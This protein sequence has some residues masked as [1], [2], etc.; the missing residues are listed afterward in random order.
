MPKYLIKSSFID[1]SL[2]T[3]LSKYLNDSI[4]SEK[5]SSLKVHFIYSK[6]AFL[7]CPAENP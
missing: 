1:N 2:F 3:I 7:L 6:L 5:F 4:S